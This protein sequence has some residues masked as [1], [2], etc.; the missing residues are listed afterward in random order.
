MQN[1]FRLRRQSDKEN[2]QILCRCFTIRENCWPLP[3]EQEGRQA[4]RQGGKREMGGRVDHRDPGT[5]IRFALNR[6]VK[7]TGGKDFEEVGKLAQ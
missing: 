5:V 6:S 4:G 7:L 1:Y 2:Q 3:P